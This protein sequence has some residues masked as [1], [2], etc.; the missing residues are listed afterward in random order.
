LIKD[1]G[2]G[3]FGRVV[4]AIDLNHKRDIKRD[5]RQNHRDRRDRKSKIKMEDTVAIKIV[6][7]VKR[8]HESAL[9]EA[10]ILKDV[11]TRGGRGQSLCA[12]LLRQFDL[13]GHYCLVFECLGRSLYDF[14]KTHGF[15]A[16][17]LFCVSD[18]ARQLLDVLDFIH[19]FGLIHTDLKPENILLM[20]NKERPYRLP[21]G[22]DQQVPA[23]TSIKLIDFGGATYDRDKKS[24][25]INTRQYRAPEVI[26][27][28]GWSIP[29]D[30][31][32]A[33]C[34]IAELYKGELLFATHDNSEHLALI[35]RVIGGLPLEM[36]SRSKEFGTRIFDAHGWHKMDTLSSESK[37]HVRKAAVLEMNV[38]G[39]DKDSGFASLLRDL[40]TINPDQ[41]ASAGNAL[42]N[43]FFD[44]KNKE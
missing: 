13:N 36:V 18:F 8:Y 4:Q 10:D 16:F 44:D 6:R 11:N 19:S 24:T 15:K 22:S 21:D 28:L 27:G 29:S 43:S 2:L 42:R 33:G 3:T 40:L 1:V 35:E 26:L 38:K 12:V 41:R 39:N 25:I 31:W 14:M 34:I 7:N 20:S 37:S 9:I 17:P 30:L 23:S 5:E 32:S